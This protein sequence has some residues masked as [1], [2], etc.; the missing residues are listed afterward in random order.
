MSKRIKLIGL[1]VII[2]TLIIFIYY[3]MTKEQ[4]IEIESKDCSE[5]T[6]GIIDGK[7][8]KVYSNV[9]Q[10]KDSI[11]SQKLMHGDYMIQFAQAY[12]NKV[13]IYYY[14]AS[15]ADGLIKT[16][17]IIN[18]LNW[19]VYHNISQVNLSVSGKLHSNN[20]EVWIKDHHTSL[21]IYTS[22]S[23]LLNSLDYP[24]M[25]NYVIASGSN[26][27]INYKN[28]DRQYRSD[29]IILNGKSYVGNSYLSIYTLLKSV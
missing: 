17:G 22:Y 26:S 24:S 16:D 18:G 15:N 19:M 14:D 20:L 13:T 27:K 6:I 25:Y 28:I 5:K 3:I 10:N 4:K 23:N 29:T 7:L 9:I 8:S 11:S 2:F 1:T 21:Q 12:C